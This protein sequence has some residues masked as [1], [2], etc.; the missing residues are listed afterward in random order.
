MRIKTGTKT[1]GIMEKLDLITAKLDFLQD[2]IEGCYDLCGQSID[3]LVTMDTEYS[4]LLHEL[5]KGPGET[6]LVFG[7]ER[8]PTD[9]QWPR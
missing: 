8:A 3:T 7:P 1:S 5:T 6:I 2:R 4:Q 9:R